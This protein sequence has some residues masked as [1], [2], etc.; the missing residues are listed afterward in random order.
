[1]AGWH[2]Y[3]LCN[4]WLPEDI[5]LAYVNYNIVELISEL[6]QAL[7]ETDFVRLGIV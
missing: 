7:W 1:M 5:V 2:I 4:S 6:H 3:I